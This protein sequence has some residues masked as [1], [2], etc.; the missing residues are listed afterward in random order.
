MSQGTLL[1]PVV[2]AI[3]PP[4]KPK[5]RL[6]PG[7]SEQI[8]DLVVTP[9]WLAQRIVDYFQPSGVLLDPARGTGP[10]FRAMQRYSKDVRWCEKAAGVDFFTWHE[11]VDWI[12]TNPPFS[13]LRRFIQHAMTLAPNIAF[14]GTCSQ[15]M[16]KAR[17]RDMREAGFGL[18]L[19]AFDQPPPPW[20]GCGFQPAVGY[21]RKGADF[22]FVWLPVKAPPLL[23][24][25]ANA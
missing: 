20:P 3:V 11:P 7:K 12:I 10:F 13:K 5:R 19:I 18:R 6:V 25:I 1:F 21:M 23:R 24:E 4:A 16:L 14:V 9:E 15:F 17:L 2:S 8:H 22:P